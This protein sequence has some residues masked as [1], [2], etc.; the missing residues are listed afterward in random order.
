[1]ARTI[2]P[3]ERILPVNGHRTR[4]I[5]EPS[6]KLCSYVL[7]VRMHDR[8]VRIVR[9]PGSS[10]RVKIVVVGTVLL[11]ACVTWKPAVIRLSATSVTVG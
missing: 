6:L 11:E 3:L 10:Y 8:P 5:D 7:Y 1:M 4:R 2:V 9:H